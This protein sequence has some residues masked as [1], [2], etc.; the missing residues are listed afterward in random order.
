MEYV[1]LLW[2][3]NMQFQNNVSENMI[4]L[5]VSLSNTGIYVPLKERNE[6]N[7]ASWNIS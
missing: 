2:L 5:S 7:A 6:S 1:S 4:I 3:N